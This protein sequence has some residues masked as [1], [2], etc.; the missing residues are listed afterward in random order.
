[1]IKKD[2]FD[3]IQNI[4]ENMLETLKKSETG[5]II[6]IPDGINL[7]DLDHVHFCLLLEIITE[8]KENE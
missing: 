7:E 3:L 5:E 2:Y 1:M 8:E 6:E 4:K